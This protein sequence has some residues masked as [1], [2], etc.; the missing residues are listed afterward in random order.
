MA[1]KRQ[2]YNQMLS[3]IPAGVALL[4]A[5]ADLLSFDFGRSRAC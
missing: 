1:G 3:L 2:T 4:D 5:P